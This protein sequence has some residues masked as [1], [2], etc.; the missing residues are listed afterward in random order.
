MTGIVTYTLAAGS[1]LVPR[2]SPEAPEDFPDVLR[3]LAL[4]GFQHETPERRYSYEYGK[5]FVERGIFPAA[6][7]C[8]LRLVEAA[9]SLSVSLADPFPVL[10]SAE[11][12]LPPNRPTDR[13]AASLAD[14]LTRV[15]GVPANDSPWGADG[16]DGPEPAPMITAP[17]RHP[18][19]PVYPVPKVAAPF[20]GWEPSDLQTSFDPDWSLDAQSVVAAAPAQLVHGRPDRV[21]EGFVEPWVFIT[22][23]SILAYVDL[24]AKRRA[25][26]YTA[27]AMVKTN[28]RGQEREHWSR[29]RFQT[30]AQSPIVLANITR[31]ISALYFALQGS[32]AL[33]AQY[34]KDIKPRKTTP[35]TTS[36]SL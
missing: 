15:K 9:E 26:N 11:H 12:L 36:R 22:V 3:S 34:A 27:R 7:E 29:I 1:G 17:P 20:V 14:K 24:L 31:R 4:A 21:G 2:R 19:D 18:S 6:D 16:A 8:P 13:D 23:E 30:K 10:G 5:G 35:H 32:P 25:E 28:V 33:T